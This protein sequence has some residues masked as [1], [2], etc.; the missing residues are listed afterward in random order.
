M[1]H[2]VNVNPFSTA[3]PSLLLLS[4]YHRLSRGAEPRVLEVLNVGRGLDNNG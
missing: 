2:S 1:T 4:K 3:L